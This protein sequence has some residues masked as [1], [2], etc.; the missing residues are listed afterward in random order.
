[1]SMRLPDS[2]EE[3]TENPSKFGMPT[4]EEFRKNKERWMG[5]PD[6]ELAAIDAG[7]KILGCRQKYF[8]EGDGGRYSCDS[9]E[10][11]QRI[12]DDMGLNLYHDFVIDPQLRPDGAAGFYNEVTFRA[13]AFLEKRASW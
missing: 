5:R 3:L 4:F 11:V 1:M 10:H 7:D 2:I 8:I 6:D 13:K 9:L 12:A